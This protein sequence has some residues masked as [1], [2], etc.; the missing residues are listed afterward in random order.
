MKSR[1]WATFVNLLLV[2][3]SAACGGSRSHYAAVTTM[4]SPDG[5]YVR[6]WEQPDFRGASDFLNG[7]RHYDDLRNFP[8][9]RSWKNRI[10][11]LHLGPNAVVIA[12]SEE[13]LRGKNALL[14]SDGRQGRFSVV[15]VRIQSLD[16][17][18]VPSH[19]AKQTTFPN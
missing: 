11:S 14:I 16:V 8:R 2:A 12:W 3:T 19:A 13:R 17:R 18:C 4:P 9:D 6:V 7:P 15:P 10:R 5:C 1:S